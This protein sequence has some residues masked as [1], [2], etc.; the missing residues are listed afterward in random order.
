MAKKHQRRKP[1]TE[2]KLKASSGVWRWWNQIT[3]D[4][5][6]FD[7]LE[8]VKRA[9]KH[10]SG[11]IQE[12]SHGQIAASAYREG[13]LDYPDTLLSLTDADI[14]EVSETEYQQDADL[15]DK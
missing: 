3:S 10:R 1:L 7:I 8:A 14:P 12:S 9:C 4:P 6:F 13:F 11:T 15:A 2:E 5:R